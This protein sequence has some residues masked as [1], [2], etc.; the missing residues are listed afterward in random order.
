MDRPDMSLAAALRGLA[1]PSG[2]LSLIAR[3]ESSLN[4]IRRR[5][6]QTLLDFRR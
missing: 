4:R 1:E 6:H 2:T 5:C 3:Y